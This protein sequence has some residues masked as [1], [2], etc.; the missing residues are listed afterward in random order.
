MLLLLLLL[1]C[2]SDH[3]TTSSSSAYVMNTILPGLSIRVL[4]VEPACPHLLRRAL[5]YR[6]VQSHS[7]LLN[8]KYKHLIGPLSDQISRLTAYHGNKPDGL[9][10]R[11]L[12]AM[13]SPG[14]AE[15]EGDYMNLSL[16]MKSLELEYADSTRPQESQVILELTGHA[17][18]EGGSRLVTYRLG[19]KQSFLDTIIDAVL[20][21]NGRSYTRTQ[22]EMR[23]CECVCEAQDLYKQ[24]LQAQEGTLRDAESI[25]LELE[26]HM[27]GMK[28]EHMDLE[29]RHRELREQ[30]FDKTTTRQEVLQLQGEVGRLTRANE[31]LSLKLMNTR[32][33]SEQDSQEL[34]QLREENARL[35][36]ESQEQ[37]GRIG[38]LSGTL[39]EIEGKHEARIEALMTAALT[40]ERE[41]NDLIQQFNKQVTLIQ[42]QVGLLDE[43]NLHITEYEKH[44]AA[45][46][47][48]Q[49][50][51]E[52]W[53]NQQEQ[54]R[55]DKEEILM[56]GN[57]DPQSALM[58]Q[59]REEI[60]RRDME[61]TRREQALQVRDQ[62]LLTR[63]RQLEA[64]EKT[65]SE[66]QTQAQQKGSGGSGGG[67]AQ[68]GEEAGEYSA[69]EG[70][71]VTLEEW[72]QYMDQRHALMLKY[73]LE[74][75][76][77]RK[78]R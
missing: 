5:L 53:Y 11:F 1:L 64:R 62:E 38:Q 72:R 35:R 44:I 42:E 43:A 18:P 40:Q 73:N 76:E 12:Q 49:T 30:V 28:Q 70:G 46:E 52:E 63:E 24:L 31:A 33:G 60:F 58:V 21:S 8:N 47:L 56:S 50:Q 67:G 74:M 6:T 32:S 66:A 51:Q 15:E 4:S 25:V 26:G 34:S 75:E 23:V 59:R 19:S 14:E 65:Q 39:G 61:L 78:V 22:V 37:Q 2:L 41:Y 27:I 13:G 9:W 48:Y 71:A 77:L 36:Q 20:V 10:V 45:L 55:R 3:G 17:S 16:H 69:L 54:L 68:A 7:S 29:D 57:K